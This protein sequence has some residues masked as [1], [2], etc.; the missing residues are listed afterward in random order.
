MVVK[1]LK[2]CIP[3][4]AGLLAALLLWLGYCA[5]FFWGDHYRL[6]LRPVNVP[7]SGWQVLAGQGQVEDGVLRLE[8]PGPRGEVLAAGPV[9]G[10]LPGSDIERV[11]VRFEQTGDYHMVGIGLSPAMALSA[12]H[13][14]TGRWLDERSVEVLEQ[15]LR[16]DSE[17]I[18]LVSLGIRGNVSPGFVVG[19]VELHRARP[20]WTGLQSM[21]FDSLVDG[22][23]WT[24]RSINH[25]QSGT[26]PLRLSP[27]VVVLVWLM[28]AAALGWLGLRI[29]TVAP[30]RSL[31]VTF[32]LMVLGAMGLLDLG[33]QLSL[34]TRHADALARYS[35]Q[36]PVERR[37]HGVDAGL[38]RF[39]HDLKDQLADPGRR[40]VVFAATEFI[41]RRA[42][43]YAIPHPVIG[44]RG[45][46]PRWVARMRPGEVLLVFDRSDLAELHEID[47]GA[48]ALPEVVSSHWLSEDLQAPAPWLAVS[49]WFGGG[50]DQLAKV[51]LVVSAGSTGWSRLE[52][53]SQGADGSVRPHAL[54]EFY[55]E[56]EGERTLVLPFPMSEAGRYRFRF[57]TLGVDGVE[58]RVAR[59]L[60]VRHSSDLI[61]L[62][63]HD[64][65]LRFLVR[66]LQEGEF[67]SAWEIP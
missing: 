28:I 51:E 52:V 29:G 53:L 41:F 8:A 57:R 24:Q 46:D 44:K 1:P 62:R 49:P 60:P 42:M 15:D 20:D 21:L 31:S 64:T 27:V 36:S 17:P 9:I 7:L 39:V 5:W 63:P 12:V 40:M 67:G 37:E 59:L 45:L 3:A 38:Y 6:A 33:W 13:R 32:G 19:S 11:I 50:P 58:V 26:A 30:N 43:Y 22:S 16:L 10:P 23:E 56:G 25:A 61:V 65:S 47:P 35:G 18:R 2:L 54:R 34:W 55:L 66:R 4:L 14:A 48:G